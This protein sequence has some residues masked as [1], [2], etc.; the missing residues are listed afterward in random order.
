MIAGENLLDFTFFFSSLLAVKRKTR[1]YVS[2]YFKDIHGK[3]KRK[4]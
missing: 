2:K 4:P 1:W 3:R